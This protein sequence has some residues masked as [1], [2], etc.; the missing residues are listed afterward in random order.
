MIIVVI[1]IIV[2]VEFLLVVLLL[3]F[4]CY[5]F[6]FDSCGLLPDTR[7]HPSL[8]NLIFGCSVAAPLNLFCLGGS[9]FISL[10]VRIKVLQESHC[11]EKQI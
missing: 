3:L 1:I 6:K 8:G 4:F 5:S 2:I 7:S 10:A 11:C 9:S